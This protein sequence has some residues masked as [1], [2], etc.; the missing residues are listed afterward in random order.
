ML[1]DGKDGEEVVIERFL[2]NHE[3]LTY[4]ADLGLNLHDHL[5]IIKHEPFEGPIVVERVH[6]QRQIMV[7]FKASHNIFINE[8]K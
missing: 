3:L 6:D 4:L 1:A 7:S 2:D 8:V 5:K